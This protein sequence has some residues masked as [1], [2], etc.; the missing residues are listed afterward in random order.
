MP[1]DGNMRVMMLTDELF[2]DAILADVMGAQ[3]QIRAIL[4]VEAALARDEMPRCA[5]RPF[6]ICDE[7]PVM[8]RD[9][10][11]TCEVAA[12]TLV[13][14]TIVPPLPLVILAYAVEMWETAARQPVSS[15]VQ[16]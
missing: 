15:N 5:G 4:R 10:Y 13:E 2:S 12:T 16:G 6:V 8:F 14:V 1:R 11:R 3:A 7:K 9:M